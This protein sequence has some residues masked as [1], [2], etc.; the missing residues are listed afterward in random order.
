M[1]KNITNLC[2]QKVDISRIV[3]QRLKQIIEN[4]K[5]K[6]G[7]LFFGKSKSEHHKDGSEHSDYS[8]NPDSCDWNEHSD[9]VSHEDYED[10]SEH[11][12]YEDHTDHTDKPHSEYS[13]YSESDYHTDSRSPKS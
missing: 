7:F 3:N 5:T 2:N 13:Q 6:E 11:T 1:N 9:D 8:G 4:Y 12:E 10:Y